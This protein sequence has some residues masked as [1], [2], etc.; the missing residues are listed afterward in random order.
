MNTTPRPW[1]YGPI[2]LG[3]PS[4]TIMSGDEQVGYIAVGHFLEANANLIVTA[5]NEYDARVAKVAAYE[6]VL[7]H[8]RALHAPFEYSGGAPESSDGV[9]CHHCETEYPCETVTILDRE[10]GR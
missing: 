9:A 10:A 7:A 8:V 3:V 4:T 5:V 1:R 2:I 6:D